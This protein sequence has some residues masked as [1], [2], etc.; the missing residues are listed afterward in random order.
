MKSSKAF[1]LLT[2]AK[3]FIAILFVLCV[4]IFKVKGQNN[5]IQKPNIIFILADDMGYGD[6]SCYNPESKIRTPNIDRLAANGIKLTNAHSASSVCTP[7]RYSIMTGRYPFRSK[8]KFGVLWTYDWPLIDKGTLTVGEFLKDNGYQT[9]IVGKWH[10]GWNWPIKPGEQID[11]NKLGGRNLQQSKA[12]EQQI[13][14]TRPLTG[15]PLA[16]GF[17]YQ[18]GIDIPSLPPFCFIENGKVLGPPL[19]QVKNDDKGTFPGYVQQG[20]NSHYIMPAFMDKAALFV[21]EKAKTG[22]PFFLYL[23][24]AIPHHPIAPGKAYKGKSKMGEYGDAVQE[25][26]GY[27]GNLMQQLKE[28]NIADNTLV[29][30]A[31]D[32]GSI[33]DAGSSTTNGEWSVA[34]A[35]YKFFGHKSNK[36]FRGIKGDIYEGGHRVPFIASWPKEIPAGGSS[37]AAI[38]LT[39]FFATC[40]GIINIPL[41]DGCADDSFDLSPILK[42]KNTKKPVRPSIIFHSSRGNLA[43][44]KGNWKYI[45]CNNSGG[46]LKNPLVKDTIYATP[47]QLYNIQT[48]PAEKDNLYAKYP[49]KVRELA[50]LLEH[51]KRSKGTRYSKL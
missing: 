33:M 16:C 40:A 14:I 39:D 36:N 10:L 24:L 23:P 12:R 37:D 19:T 41:P 1:T 18:F 49:Q 35:G 32:N 48:D 42:G 21:S 38:S 31:S 51:H 4:S 46:S 22:Q 5:K 8:M 28:L 6:L 43:I 30:F 34:G 2:V 25:M 15:G 17:D 47:G 13:D 50:A 7:S 26:D 3:T 45:D 29:I 27:I 11:T 44:E 20:W 9:G